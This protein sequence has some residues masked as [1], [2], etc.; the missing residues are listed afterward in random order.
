MPEQL[1]VFPIALFSAAATISESILRNSKVKAKIKLTCSM[2]FRFSLFLFDLIFKILNSHPPVQLASFGIIRTVV[3]RVW[4]HGLVSPYPCEMMRLWRCLWKE[5]SHRLRPV[6]TEGHIVSHRSFA[7]GMG[8][9]LNFNIGV[10]FRKATT[11]SSST[12]IWG[13][14]LYLSKSKNTLFSRNTCLIS[15]G[16]RYRSLCI[17]L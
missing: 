14:R 2:L 17:S 4:R 12:A 9:H 10:L 13:A 7:V 15:I 3:V 6:I 11:R 1:V 8:A 16:A 5:Y